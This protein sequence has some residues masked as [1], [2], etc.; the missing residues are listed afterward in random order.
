MNYQRDEQNFISLQE[1]LDDYVNNCS[2]KENFPLQVKEL[3][4]ILCE[5]F[6]LAKW[7]WE[8]LGIPRIFL[9]IPKNLFVGILKNS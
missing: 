4:I 7:N 3:G 9:R 1:I 8:F 6:P 2:E 5:A